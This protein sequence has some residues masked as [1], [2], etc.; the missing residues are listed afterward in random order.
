MPMFHISHG[1]ERQT[2]NYNIISEMYGMYLFLVRSTVYQ[3]QHKWE[4]CSF[5]VVLFGLLQ[6]L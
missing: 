4:K 2:M 6:A 1:Q 3:G 5:V